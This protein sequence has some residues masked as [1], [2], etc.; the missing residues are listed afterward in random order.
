MSSFLA[1]DGNNEGVETFGRVSAGSQTHAERVGDAFRRTVGQTG[2]DT[3]SVFEAVYQ[4]KSTPL[5]FL[6]GENFDVADCAMNTLNGLMRLTSSQKIGGGGITFEKVSYFTDDGQKHYA[7]M[8]KFA[9]LTGEKSDNFY[10]MRNNVVHE[11]G[12]L[13]QIAISARG[14]PKGDTPYD[15][16]SADMVSDR[17]LRRGTDSNQAYGFAS[18]GYNLAWQQHSCYVDDLSEPYPPCILSG[19]IFADQFLG[20]TY[21]AWETRFNPITGRLE[22]STEAEVRSE[23]M[24]DN[25]YRWL[26]GLIEN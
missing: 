2:R 23:W 22:L 19:E 15:K 25:M 24:N 7:R 17:R 12:H 4:T 11:L 10:K 21:D 18:P 26:N 6:F 14:W 16:L 9:S 8:I 5:I 1:L 13:F 3:L 20:W